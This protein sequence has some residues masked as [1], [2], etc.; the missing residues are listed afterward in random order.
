MRQFGP[1]AAQLETATR[2]AREDVASCNPS[3]GALRLLRHAH[4]SRAY[5]ENR[6]QVQ[7]ANGL[8]RSTGRASVPHRAQWVHGDDHAK[9]RRFDRGERDRSDAQTCQDVVP[10]MGNHVAAAELRDLRLALGDLLIGA[11]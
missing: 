3:W 9:A 11:A 1:T 5:A 8:Q 10:G 4:T 7:V 2:L 6:C